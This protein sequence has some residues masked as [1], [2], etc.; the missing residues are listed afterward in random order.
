MSDTPR[1]VSLDQ[2][3]T[4]VDESRRTALKRLLA[5]SA[6]FAVPLITAI[7]K[8]NDAQAAAGGKGIGKGGGKGIGK[9]KI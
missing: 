4:S 6:T 9:A 3:M 2:V 7:V 1:E 8:S 5:G